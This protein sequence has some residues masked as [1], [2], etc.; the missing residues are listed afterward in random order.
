MTV[1]VTQAICCHPCHAMF[2]L[3]RHFSAGCCSSDHGPNDEYPNRT[4]PAQNFSQIRDANR[5]EIVH[6]NSPRA[7]P[8]AYQKLT[9]NIFLLHVDHICQWETF[10]PPFSLFSFL[11]APPAPFLSLCASSVDANSRP[12]APQFLNPSICS[13]I[14]HWIS[15]QAQV[16]PLITPNHSTTITRNRAPPDPS[17]SSLQ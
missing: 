3:C 14:P 4:V 13:K 11:V 17:R 7:S 5:T 9:A 8:A 15:C 10:L 1:Q 16:P 2:R 6:F 12:R